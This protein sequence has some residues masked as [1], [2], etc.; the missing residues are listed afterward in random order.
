MSA[1]SRILQALKTIFLYELLIK[2]G[3]FADTLFYLCIN[4]L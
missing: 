4:T 3:V 2:K 1:V